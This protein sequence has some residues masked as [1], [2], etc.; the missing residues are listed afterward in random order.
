MIEVELPDGTI[1]EFPE[2]TTPEAMSRAIAGMGVQEQPQYAA[3][4]V[5][6]NAAAKAEIAARAKSG[7]MAQPRETA[8]MRDMNMQAEQDMRDPGALASAALGFNQGVTFGFGDEMAAAVQALS[9]DVTYD[10]AL[11]ANRALLDNAKFSRPITT[12]AA[13]VGGAIA[14]SL[15]ATGPAVLSR[16]TLAGKAAVGGA[17]GA[18]EGGLYGFGTGE[19][20]FSER[21]SN[22]AQGAAVGGLVGAAAPVAIAGAAKAGQL[23]SNPVRSALNIPSDVRAS[24]AFQT[25]LQRSGMSADELMA[26]IQQAAD[27]GQPM[28]VTADALGNSGQ[29]ALAGIARQPG[30]ARQ[31]I[32]DM[33]TQRQGSQGDRLSGFLAEALDAPDTAAQRV[34]SLTQARSVAADAAYGA[35]RGN[36]AP[37][38]VRGALAA[39]DDRIGP[40]QGM[41]VAGDSIDS[42]LASFRSRLAANNPPAGMTGV[43]LSDFDR[44]LGVKQDVQDAI[45]AAIRAGRN[46]EAR[47][48]GKLV[49]ELDAALEGSSDMYRAANDGFRQASR[50]IDAVDEGRGAVSSRVRSEDVLQRFQAM[51]PEQ[52]AAFRAGYADPRIAAIDAAAPGVNKARPLRSEKATA[53]LGAMASDPGLLSRRIDR[54]NTMFETYAS[55]LGGSK[56]ADNMADGADAVAMS[57]SGIAN[58]LSGGVKGLAIA[59]AD[60]LLA[61]ATGLN[62]AT[63]EMIARMLLSSDPKAAITPAVKAA[64]KGGRVNDLISA[65][66]RGAGRA[67]SAQ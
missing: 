9:P 49:T 60:R 64:T 17:T 4:G 14:P 27:E 18:A 15:L 51:T 8:A 21:A 54:E 56:T 55:A 33:L 30:D 34:A 52:Q 46:N 25:Y 61:G 39:I 58:A 12:G 10:Q 31:A 6:M 44:V 62:P 37:V 2:G 67:I 32:A 28:F 57:A 5:P 42:R 24:R 36:A 29:R 63:R 59:G 22:A 40:M 53:E 38:D 16:A 20:G 3:N 48:L 66:V 23:V 11:S 47:E 13:E 26:R 45:G 65:M 43:E 19:G 1:I 50:V 41:G 7:E 35:A